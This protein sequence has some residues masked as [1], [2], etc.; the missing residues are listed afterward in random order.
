MKSLVAVALLAL[1]ALRQPASSAPLKGSCER[2]GASI[3]GSR[4]VVPERG[5]PFP[6]KRVHKNPAWP[7]LPPG[8]SVTGNWLGELLVRGD[9]TVA[10]VW[11]IRE[12][13]LTPAFSPFNQAILDALGQW[14]YDPW[15]IGGS[16]TPFCVTVTMHIDF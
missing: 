3:V 6:R 5:K 2:E 13:K 12:P 8:T 7:D 16:A 14:R 9:G 10:R 1:V 11:P 15:L 4:P